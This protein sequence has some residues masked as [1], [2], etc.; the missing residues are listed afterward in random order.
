MEIQELYKYL[1]IGKLPVLI[2]CEEKY[3]SRLYGQR[4]GNMHKI[5]RRMNGM[6]TVFEAPEGSGIRLWKTKIYD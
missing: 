3:K 5:E 6:V 2:Y 4:R 1:E